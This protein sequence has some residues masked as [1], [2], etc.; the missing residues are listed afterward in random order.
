[1]I[2]EQKMKRLKNL[3]D[4]KKKNKKKKNYYFTKQTQE[5]IVEY[6]NKAPFITFHLKV[7]FT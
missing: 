6:Q 5:M 4:K 3:S 1:M 2:C 7:S